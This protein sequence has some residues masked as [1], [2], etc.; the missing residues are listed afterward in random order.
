MQFHLRPVYL[1]DDYRGMAELFGRVEPA[2]PVSAGDLQSEDQGIPV[3]PDLSLNDDGLLIG[4]GRERVLAVNDD[5]RVIGF[6]ATWRA[7]W[8]PSG[9]LLSLLCVEPTCR[10]RGVGTALLDHLESW[11]RAQGAAILE[12]ETPDEPPDIL[13]FVQKRGY[14]VDAHVVGFALNLATFD[15]SRCSGV[16][17][18]VESSGIRLLALADDP[19]EMATM[20]IY[21]LYRETLRDNPGWIGELPAFDEWRREALDPSKARHDRVLI[22]ADGDRFV[23]VTNLHNTPQPSVLHTD[24]TGVDRGYRGRQ[25]GL[26]LKLLSCRA[27][28]RDGATTMTTETETSNISMLAINRTLGYARGSGRY[29]VIKR[30]RPRR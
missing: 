26:A 23:G 21:E 12:S 1:P 3:E 16:I 2:R 4:H 25:I 14:D 6:G 18:V 19:S 11:G 30:L 17:E 27:A 24:Y 10:R 9:H 22:A 8:T 28:L 7:P 29:R 20:K 15:E 13:A 5:G